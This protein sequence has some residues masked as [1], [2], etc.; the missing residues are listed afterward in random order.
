MMAAVLELK[1]RACRQIRDGTRDEDLVRTGCITDPRCGMHCDASQITVGQQ[2]N[3]THVQSAPH[4]HAEDVYAA[5]DF[6][7][8]AQGVAREVESD[9]MAVSG[10]LDETPPMDLDDLGDIRVEIS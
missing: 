10:L 2:L 4:L 7:S 3:L 9:Q 6:A 1:V 8:G 5:G